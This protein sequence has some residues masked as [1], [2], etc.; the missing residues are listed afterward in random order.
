M[1]VVAWFLVGAVLGWWVSEVSRAFERKPE[2]ARSFPVPR[3]TLLPVRPLDVRDMLLGC[4]EASIEC[5]STRKVD[6]LSEELES[7]RSVVC[8]CDEAP[9]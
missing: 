6:L 4:V 3:L 7:T 5:A 9:P 1:K 8:S 2:R